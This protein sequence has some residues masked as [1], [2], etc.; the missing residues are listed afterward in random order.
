VNP[1]GKGPTKTIT[2]AE[3]SA[4]HITLTHPDAPQPHED[5]HLYTDSACSMHMIRRIMDAPWTLRESKHFQLLNNILDALRTRA[6][7]G[8]QTYIYKVRSHTGVAGNEAADVGAV[9]AAK[10]PNKTNT[11][12]HSENDPYSKRTWAAHVPT[13]AKARLDRQ[14]KSPSDTSP[15]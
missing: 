13:K 10:N 4:T 3:L 11:T 14:K 7:A 9:Y 15:A 12:E 8:G 6:E 1:N 2:R 5:I